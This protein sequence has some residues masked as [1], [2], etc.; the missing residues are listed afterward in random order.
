MITMQHLIW[1][2]AAVL[3]A[4]IFERFIS[5]FSRRNI[6]ESVRLDFAAKAIVEQQSA[7]EDL[8]ARDTLPALAKEYLLGFAE[9]ALE[10]RAAHALLAVVSGA[11]PPSL[12]TATDARLKEYFQAIEDFR[13]KDAVGYEIYKTFIFKVPITSFLQWSETYKAIGKLSLRLAEERENG[14]A[15]D[16]VVM[17]QEAIHSRNL[18]GLA[19]PA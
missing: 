7:L 17:R 10:K 5:H 8:L 1:T 6:E 13:Q 19:A 18:G 3:L 16:A 14:A 9:A 4:V 15:L 11:A 2:L 12:G